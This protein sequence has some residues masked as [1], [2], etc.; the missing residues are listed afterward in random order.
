MKVVAVTLKASALEAVGACG[1]SAPTERARVCAGV[2]VGAAVVQRALKELH[3][4]DCHHAHGEGTEPADVKE[5]RDGPQGCFTESVHAFNLVEQHQHAQHAEA[6]HRRVEDGESREEHDHPRRDDDGCLEELPMAQAASHC[7]S[8]DHKL[9][10]EDREKDAVPAGEEEFILVRRGRVE[11]WRVKSKRVEVGEDHED[12]H[13]LKRLE[14]GQRDCGALQPPL[15]AVYV[16]PKA[17]CQPALGP[18]M[19]GNSSSS[20]KASTRRAEHGKSQFFDPKSNLSCM[21]DG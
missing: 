20:L 8:P 7:T 11:L 14:H 9:D 17:H 4:D 13:H 10:G 5:R 16:A 12:D 15:L 1:P 3:A 18:Y 21:R 6:S 19:F 2:G